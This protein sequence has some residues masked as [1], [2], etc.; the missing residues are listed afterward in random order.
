VD[1]NN[2]VSLAS[3]LPGSV[4]D[5]DLT[6]HRLHL[7]F[8]EA[9]ESYVFNPAGQTIDLEDLLVV[10][11]DIHGRWEPCGNP[12]KDAM[13]TKIRETTTDVVGI[14]YV[15]RSL[16]RRAAEGWA[17]RYAELLDACCRPRQVGIL[18]MDRT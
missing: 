4:F 16:G 2:V 13:T 3:G 10:C 8:G 18:P 9:G 5:T 1:V 12:V 17:A 11:R 14:L 15:P 6:G 7:R